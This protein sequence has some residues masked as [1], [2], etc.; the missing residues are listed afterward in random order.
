MKKF[1]P[2]IK[3]VQNPNGPTLG[4][5]T[6]SGVGIIEKDGLAFK[7]LAKDGV[8]HPYVDWR[9]SPEERAEDLA[10]RL[11]IEQLAG[12]ILHSSHQFVPGIDSP[13]FGNTLYG[14]KSRAESGAPAYALS[15]K[16]IDKI[17]ND[18][19]RH[20]LVGAV[21]TPK[22]A[23]MWNNNLQSLAEEMPF[24]IPIG[25][26][27]DPRHGTIVS[28]EFDIGASGDTSHWSEP[29]GLAATFDPEL[30]RRF[31]GVASQEYR[32][33][34][35]TT[36]LS[37][38]IDLATDPR[39]TRFQGTFGESPALSADMARAYCD[40]FQTS[41]GERE[42]KDGWG[43][44]SVNAM[45]KHWP[46][47]GAIEGGRDAHFACGKY[48]V[49]PGNNF[50]E[51]LAPFVD[52]AFKLSGKTQRASAVMPY[53]TVVYDQDIKYGENV[54]CSYS[55]YLITDL[56]RDKFGYDE[57]V[58]TDWGILRDPAPSVD[59]L[60]GGKCWGVENLTIEERCYKAF[61]AGVDQFG[62]LDDKSIVMSAYK[63]GV[64]EY[65]EEAMRTRFEQSGMRILRNLF[66]TGLFENPYLD[67]EVSAAL[68]GSDKFV[69]AGY[70]AQIKSTV[71]LKNKESTLPLQK[72]TKLYIP[73]LYTPGFTDWMGK[74]HE[75]S[76]V[77]PIDRNL[78]K[79]Y[80]DVVDEPEQADASLCVIRMPDGA[81]TSMLDG[82][83]VEDR[84]NGGNGYVPVSLQYRP[85]TADC[86]R[87][88]SIAGGDPTE[89]FIDRSYKGKSVTVDNES[90][91]DVVLSTKEKMGD[92]PVIVYVKMTGPL[93]MAEFEP[94]ADAIIGSFGEQPKATLEILCGIHEPSGLLP[95]QIPA[96]M[97]TVEE[98]FEDVPFDME[99]HV[100]SEG[101]V[102]DFSFGMNWS[103]VINDERV[104]KYSEKD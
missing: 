35:I 85:Y 55:K 83:S 100:D 11:S 17:R 90:D 87:E 102:Y 45:V 60:M 84:K 21:Q 44:D 88:V 103:G 76:W 23:A 95:M 82:Y 28:M 20:M 9:L 104:I 16:Q 59:S 26:S 31:G 19:I 14:G 71:L 27:S 10:K 98:Q 78:V 67:A 94:S 49:Y 37:P 96:N 97:E 30:V 79:Q 48:S 57:L 43:F 47:G 1:V 25:L 74:T 32:A 99:C 54:G 18:F 101:H 65:G 70:D 58:C 92:K 61:M 39:W 8:V 38:Q 63:M 91:L 40:G 62:G 73:K 4:Y 33:M 41:C 46:G 50:D 36:A 13:Y 5:S 68:V 42:T 53:Y 15:D 52:G 80:F 66:R 93:V 7:D 75:E 34:G 51:H 6:E 81:A 89:S 22:D 24:G 86:A 64:K 29:I 3:Y 69:A 56:L 77:D 72:R 12:L 2:E